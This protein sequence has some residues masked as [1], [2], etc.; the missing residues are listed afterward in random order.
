[1]DLQIKHK[2]NTTNG[3]FYFEKEHKIVAEMEYAYSEKNV[4]SI[5]HTEVKPAFKGRG[6]GIK[7]LDETV[8]FARKNNLKITA[9][10]PF[11][12]VQFERS[13]KYNDVKI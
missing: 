2:E 8:N 1:M 13:D 12:E 6:L 5:N 11:V 7:L 3:I 9:L 4:I 10:C